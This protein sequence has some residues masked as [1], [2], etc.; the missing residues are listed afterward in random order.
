ML[1]NRFYESNARYNF[2]RCLQKHSEDLTPGEVGLIRRYIVE[3]QATRH[4][5]DTRARKIGFTLVGWRR[6]IDVPFDQVTIS[7]IY[8]GIANM[9]AGMSEKGT[10]LKPNTQRDFIK[11]LKPFLLWMVD[12]NIIDLPE[13]KIK[14]IKAPTADAQTV[15][16]EELLTP[17]EVGGMIDVTLS[18]RD[19]ALVC[20]LYESGVRIGELARLTWQDIAFDEHG[21]RMYINDTKTKKRRYSRLIGSAG[22]LQALKNSTPDL[23]SDSFVFLT[24]NGEPMA[25]ITVVKILRRI[26]KRAGITKEIRPHLFRHTRITHMIQQNYQES[27]IKQSLWGNLST[28]Q[29]KT[30]VS[31]SETD[32]DNEFLKRAAIRNSVEHKIKEGP[33]RTLISSARP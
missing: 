31:L 12:E 21:A 8:R 5:T 30:Y 15:T 9:K 19:R 7:D 16:P 28:Q 20:T 1:N 18:H 29:F 13:K 6:Y 24:E 3:A 11:I 26:A 23:R 4:I 32:I 17:A 10:A 27:I 2:E 33:G 22:P 14:A 25:Y